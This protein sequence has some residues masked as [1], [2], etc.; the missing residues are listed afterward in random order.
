MHYLVTGGAGFI[1]GQLAKKLIE[2]QHQV[3]IVDDLSTGCV[4]NV[5]LSAQF[6]QGDCALPETIAR[7][8]VQKFDAILHFAGQ[9]SGEISFDDPVRDLNANTTSTLLLLQYAVRTGCKRFVYASTMSVY[10]Q[11]EGVE[12]FAEN[13]PS[14]PLSFYAVGKLASEQYLKI[15]QKQYGIKPTSLRLFNV[16]GPGQNLENLRQGMVSIYLKQFVDDSYQHVEVKGALNRFRDLIYIDDV[17]G[18]TLKL[19]ED[20]RSFGEVFNVGTGVKTTVEEIIS[21]LRFILESKK[22]T[23]MRQGT[24]GDQFGIYADV[25]KLR[26]LYSD[27]AVTSLEAGVRKWLTLLKLR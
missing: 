17:V 20:P 18:V 2:Y 1:G 19:L 6:I 27:Y 12:Q 11:R 9:S 16:Y 25:S 24:P 3:T 26:Q 8:N 7:L 14:N 21:T 10:G 15:Y 13:D 4:T 23:K 22:E 5:P